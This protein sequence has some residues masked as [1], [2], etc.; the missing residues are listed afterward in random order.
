MAP[1]SV[2]RRARR[3]LGLH[4]PPRVAVL[5]L[6]GTIGSRLGRSGLQLDE[7]EPVLK[8]A[9]TLGRTRAVALVVNSPGGAPAQTNLIAARIRS[10]AAEHGREVYAFVEDVAASGGYWLAA[11]ADRIYA[12]RA[13]IIGSIGVVSGGFGFSE[14]LARL[15]IE[16]R[17][18]TAGE[19]KAVLDPFLPERPDDV[20]HLHG[21]LASLH[22]A[23]KDT[24]RERR[25]GRLK[26]DEADLFSGAFWTAPEALE[27]GLIDGI[28][29]MHT[30]LR[31]RFGED[32]EL[33]PIKRRPPLLGRLM[34]GSS[35]GRA[36]AAMVAAVTGALAAL[37]ERA[38]W[39]RY[40]L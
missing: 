35:E 26:G 32:V 7:L 16:R 11:A 17:L 8:A 19:R 23:F 14:A 24:V 25:A 2:F 15:G 20:A 27:R 31:E 30:V 13:S 21:I 39:A 18:H 34:R 9:F 6:S 22:E 12:D 40:G 38:L 5:R 36:E 29:D 37:E 1:R 10:L 33:I 4:R 3:L 28:E